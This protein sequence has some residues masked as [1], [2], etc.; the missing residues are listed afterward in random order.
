MTLKDQINK[1]KENWLIVL[2]F[3][4]VMALFVLFPATQTLQQDVFR[5]GA[6]ASYGG[7]AESKIAIGMPT[8]FMED[9]F[10]PG[11]QQRQITKTASLSTEVKLGTFKEA[12]NQLKSIVSTADAYL[13]N[14]NSQKYGEGRQSYYYGS[15]SI[16]VEDKKYDALLMQLKQI[17]KITMFNE[18]K[19]DITEQFVDVSVELQAEKERLKRYQQMFSEATSV[20]DKIELND[21]IFNQERT[22][23]YLEEQLSNLNTRVD[24]STIYVTITE[25]QSEYINAVF[26]KFS[27]LVT[28]FVNSLNGLLKMLVGLVPYAI[29]AV[30]AWLGWKKLKKR[31]K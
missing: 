26:V 30:L 17:G 3:A 2:I 20:S 10:A 6:D 21:R 28:G 14:E 19:E 13:L 7:V 23:K 24:Y 4:A 9:S 12:E 27:E 5:T 11:V 15:Y 18:N 22:I 25:K 31:K 16:K 29:V 8:P 1:M